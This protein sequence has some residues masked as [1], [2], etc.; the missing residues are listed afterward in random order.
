MYSEETK[1]NNELV[2]ASV[3]IHEINEQNQFD[4]TLVP[5]RGEESFVDLYAVSQSHKWATL[6]LQLTY[7]VELPFIAY[8]QPSSA[9]YSGKPTMEA[10]ERKFHKL[11]HQEVDMSDLILVIQ[12]YMNR[13]TAEKVFAAQEFDKYLSY[14]FK[15]IYYVA[16]AMMSADTD[17]S[18]Q[19][20]FIVPI[21]GAFHP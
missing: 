16:P 11:S 18:L 14:P 12:G 9:D 8:E 4:Y 13:Q 3:F 2:W 20:G 19:E 17:E 21:K 15:G 6:K 7:A 5:E 1:R 10:I